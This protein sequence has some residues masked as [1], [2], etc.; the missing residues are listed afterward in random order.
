VV[1]FWRNSSLFKTVVVVMDSGLTLAVAPVGRAFTVCRVVVSEQAPEWASQL[2]DIGFMPGERVAVMARGMPGNDPLV[3]RIG[4]STFALR[5]AEAAC[6][7]IEP[8]P[9]A[10]DPTA[11]SAVGDVVEPSAR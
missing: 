8:V 6:V 2:A 9:A 10:A 11:L 3:V 7:H 4:L 5:G 1:C